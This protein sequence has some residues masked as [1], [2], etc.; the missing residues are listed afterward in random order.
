MADDMIKSSKQD[1]EII[2]VVKNSLKKDCV[3]SMKYIFDGSKND[4]NRRIREKRF[5]QNLDLY[6][7]LS[8]Q[9]LVMYN[10]IKIL[11]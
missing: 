2:K 3:K 11:I 1:R 10:I 8:L 7:K 4:L 6:M 5:I 9:I